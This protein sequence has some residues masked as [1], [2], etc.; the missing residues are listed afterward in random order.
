MQGNC[1]DTGPHPQP[2]DLSNN[3]KV[4]TLVR[5]MHTMVKDIYAHYG[6]GT[7]R[8]N[9]R[10]EGRLRAA[11]DRSRIKAIKAR[12]K[13]QVKQTHPLLQPP[14]RSQQ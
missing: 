12:G 6:R 13:L 3:S 9:R 14:L 7:E 5:E 10:L 11:K 8:D 2:S 1:G 4:N